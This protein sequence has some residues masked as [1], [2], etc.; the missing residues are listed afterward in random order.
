MASLLIIY[1]GSYLRALNTLIK[2][3]E[4]AGEKIQNF[5]IS[6]LKNPFEKRQ[7]FD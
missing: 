4:K 6:L 5:N 1:D 7:L 3:Y 2:Q